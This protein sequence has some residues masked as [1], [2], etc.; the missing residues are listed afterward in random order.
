M[1]RAFV[2]QVQPGDEYP[3]KLVKLIPAEIVAVYLA[4]Q[5]NLIVLGER[6]VV[7]AIVVLLIFTVAYLRRGGIENGLQLTFSTLSFLVWV[8]SVAPV[9]ILR[10]LYNPPL[11]SVIL[12]LWT[13]GIPFVKT[14][15]LT[16]G[17]NSG[18]DT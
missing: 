4:I 8:Y 14:D 12:A 11:A 7:G 10:G 3:D 1:S 17:G 5:A 6:V 9:E 2:R 18:G 16:S 15:A 13:L